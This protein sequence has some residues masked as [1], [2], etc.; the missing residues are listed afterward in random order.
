MEKKIYRKHGNQIHEAWNIE[1]REEYEKLLNT[2]ADG[3]TAY[4]PEL[5]QVIAPSQIH[6][7]IDMA[8]QVANTGPTPMEA[9]EVKKDE[10]LRQIRRLKTKKATGPDGLKTELFKEMVHS[11]IFIKNLTSRL[12]KTLQEGTIPGDGKCRTQRLFQRVR[13]R[14]SPN[15]LTGWPFGHPVL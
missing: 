14:A 7:H 15:M 13:N 5:S 12:N 11:E 4:W 1:R 8:I 3:I 2:T 10:V 6:E 9:Q